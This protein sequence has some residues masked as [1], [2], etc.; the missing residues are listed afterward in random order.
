MPLKTRRPGTDQTYLYSL[1]CPITFEVRYVGRSDR[2]YERLKQHTSWVRR[3]K[4]HAR[5]KRLFPDYQIPLPDPR[6][7]PKG[8]WLWSLDKRNLAPLLAIL[9]QVPA[10]RA[11]EREIHWTDKLLSEGHRLTNGERRSLD[12]R[13]REERAMNEAIEL[14][15]RMFRRPIRCG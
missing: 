3:W 2:P 8:A 12:A 11:R 6:T 7:S 4:E 14:G 9:E 5:K 10:E 13:E 15:R 1:V